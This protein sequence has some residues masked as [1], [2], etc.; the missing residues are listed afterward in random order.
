M[1]EY[2]PVWTSGVVATIRT[3]FHELAPSEEHWNS[4][5]L[6]TE[7]VR[8][9]GAFMQF[10]VIQHKIEIDAMNRHT[11]DRRENGTKEVPL[12]F[13]D[14][15]PP[16]ASFFGGA[17]LPFG[18]PVVLSPFL[19]D[20]LLDDEVARLPLSNDCYVDSPSPWELR[21]RMPRST[22]STRENSK[23]PGRQGMDK[24]VFKK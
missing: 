16:L 18:I 1:N 9:L 13:H 7:V 20:A 6:G 10:R 23:T 12:P 3:T 4:Q 22:Q 19:E 2:I 15:G 11:I 14:L 8:I 5:M 17:P 24:K 21:D